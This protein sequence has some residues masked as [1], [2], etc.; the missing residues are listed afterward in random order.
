MTLLLRRRMP[1][2]GTG[3]SDPKGRTRPYGYQGKKGRKS[4][5]GYLKRGLKALKKMDHLEVALR[6]FEYGQKVNKWLSAAQVAWDVGDYVGRKAAP[7]LAPYLAPYFGHPENPYGW[8]DV[9]A[10]YPEFIQEYPD[11][12]RTYRCSNPNFGKLFRTSVTTYTPKQGTWAVN[13]IAG[14]G[15]SA[16]PG[17]NLSVAYWTANTPGFWSHIV[18]FEK[19]RGSA[20]PS[21][22]KPYYIPPRT[23][24]IPRPLPDA[25]PPLPRL[26]DRALPVRSRSRLPKPRPYE[27]PAVEY[28]GGNRRPVLHKHMPSQPSKRE[29]KRESPRGLA[30]ALASAA[31]RA[32]AGYS[33]ARDFIDAVSRGLPKKLQREYDKLKTPQDKVKFLMD[34]ARDIDGLAAARAVAANEVEDRL[35]GGLY[36]ARR[37][38]VARAR[39]KGYGPDD[40]GFPIGRYPNLRF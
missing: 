36:N 17:N 38:A 22:P 10:D 32:L 16:N 39:R 28:D 6:G 23:L 13:C 1:K 19:R 18:S 14:Q 2:D 29:D 31:S 5:G 40:R 37:K 34:H 15:I 30:H 4:V 35:I 20:Y 7:Y 3:G 9:P 27:S 26:V 21:N 25:R 12:W 33:E 11:R 8:A 24:Q